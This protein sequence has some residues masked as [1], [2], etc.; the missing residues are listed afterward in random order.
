MH[1][2]GHLILWMH[3]RPPYFCIVLIY[4]NTMELLDFYGVWALNKG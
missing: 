2:R 1:P 4:F 3:P